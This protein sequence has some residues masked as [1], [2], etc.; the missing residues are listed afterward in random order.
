[1]DLDKNHQCDVCGQTFPNE[2]GLKNHVESIHEKNCFKCETCQTSYTTEK[3]LKYHIKIKHSGLKKVECSLCKKTF[4]NAVYLRNH[5][6]QIHEASRNHKCSTCEKAFVRPDGLR[7]HIRIV[8]LNLRPFIC[9]VCKK[10][11]TTKSTLTV[12]VNLIHKN[13][14]DIDCR[15]CGEKFREKSYLK[16][17]TETVHNVKIH[18]CKICSKNFKGV[19]A[20]NAHVKLVH[21]E[22]QFP[23][24]FCH[25][26]LNNAVQR[27]QHFDNVHNELKKKKCDFCDKIFI[28]NSVDYKEH[29]WQRHL[30]GSAAHI[31]HFCPKAFATLSRFNSHF[32]HCHEKSSFIECTYCDMKFKAK[33]KLKSHVLQFHRTCNIC[34]K[35]FGTNRDFNSH[36]ENGHKSTTC[37]ICE[38]VFS[39]EDFRQHI[40]SMHYDLK[41]TQC[42][43]CGKLFDSTLKLARHARMHDQGPFQCEICK[44][45]VTT[46][47]SLVDHLKNVHE[48]VIK[49]NSC[50]ICGQAFKLKIDLIHHKTQDHL[51]CT[52][53]LK[54]FNSYQKMNTHL[55][56]IHQ[57]GRIP[58]D[59]CGKIFPNTNSKKYHIYHMHVRKEYKCDTCEK[60]FRLKSFLKQHKWKHHG[61]GSTFHICHFCAKAFVTVRHYD[62]HFKEA[63][64]NGNN[65]DCSLC[66]KTFIRKLEFTN[67]LKHAHKND[68]ENNE[69]ENISSHESSN[70]DRN[71][72]H[73]KEKDIIEIPPTQE[74]LKVM[75][76]EEIPL[77]D[78][79]EAKRENK[80]VGFKCNIYNGRFETILKLE[81][82]V[83]DKH[84]CERTFLA[85]CNICKE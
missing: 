19:I 1:M 23:C 3:H 44:K 67:H 28:L 43:I 83:E 14:K 79:S 52:I 68:F 76:E 18:E 74:S 57:A 40:E 39:V 35:S 47:Q 27:R 75:E 77:N 17:H 30:Q 41:E 37:K 51:R 63:H 25:K 78:V 24:D 82:H 9:N 12:H 42:K 46:K 45:S 73:T 61:Q 64:R 60:V 20:L 80:Q 26:I 15:I 84:F 53:C 71:T 6:R 59:F 85:N 48:K 55:K 2:R 7:E 65:F 36:L 32:K 10:S 69:N 21:L 56:Q 4:A 33:Q 29:N 62:L 81:N 8:H 5:M 31:C 22:G 72:N 50:N 13:I 34:N 58:C 70:K 66:D 38:K 11:F 54:E 16:K 49:I